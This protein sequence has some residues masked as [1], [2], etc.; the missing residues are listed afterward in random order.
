MDGMFDYLQAALLL[1]FVGFFIGRTIYARRVLKAPPI[2]FSFR[3]RR[4][5]LTVSFFVAMTVW[6][7]LALVHVFRSYVLPPAFGMDLI[8]AVGVRIGGFAVTVLGLVLYIIAIIALGESWRVGDPRRRV[9]LVT[10][11]VYSLSRNPIYL[12]FILLYFGIFLLDGALV[13]LIFAVLLTVNIHYLIIE[14]EAWLAARYGAA[15]RD[16]RATTGRYLTRPAKR[17]QG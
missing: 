7:I 5:V 4:N 16:Y 8:S 14:E 15:F 1:T 2:T 6:F 3:D 13:L 10:W 11:G 17:R 9:G 12:S